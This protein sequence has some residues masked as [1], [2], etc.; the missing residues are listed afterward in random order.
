MSAITLYQTIHCEENIL[1]FCLLSTRYRKLN[2]P[3]FHRGE[4]E[5][6]ELFFEAKRFSVV[7]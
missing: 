1:W 3:L 5:R 7:L 4:N 2:S 6:A